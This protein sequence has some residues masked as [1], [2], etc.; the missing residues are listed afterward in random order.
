MLAADTTTTFPAPPT[1]TPVH[2][3][4]HQYKIPG[5]FVL[6][7]LVVGALVSPYF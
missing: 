5:T 3:H 2:H 6:V 7:L 1:P 4:H